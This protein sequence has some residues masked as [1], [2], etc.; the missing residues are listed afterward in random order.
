MPHEHEVLQTNS[1]GD[2]ILGPHEVEQTAIGKLADRLYKRWPVAAVLAVSA[3][4]A[5]AGIDT[6]PDPKMPDQTVLVSNEQPLEGE[7]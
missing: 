4:V 7:E 1:S 6:S 3:L 5:S 2:V